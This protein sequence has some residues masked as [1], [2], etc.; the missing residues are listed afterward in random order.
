MNRRPQSADFTCIQCGYYVPG[1]WQ[2][3]GVHHRNHCPYCLWSRHLDLLTPGDRLAACKSPM[4][5]IG[6]TMKPT[7][8]K[9]SPSGGEIMLVH[10]CVECCKLSINR[11]AADDDSQT[12]KQVFLASFTLA[13]GMRS[14]LLSSGIHMMERANEALL[15]RH[16][17]AEELAWRI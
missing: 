10:V 7:H 2:V 12:L 8:N 11:L 5:P 14:R 13:G 9:Y 17:P 6:L 16:L 15:R 1:G 4:Q 3:A